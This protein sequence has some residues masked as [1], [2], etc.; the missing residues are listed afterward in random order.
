MM[1]R[2]GCLDARAARRSINNTACSIGS[3]ARRTVQKPPLRSNA[4]AMAISQAV[5]ESTAIART[6]SV[7]VENSVTKSCMARVDLPAY[8]AGARAPCEARAATCGL[9]LTHFRVGAEARVLLNTHQTRRNNSAIAIAASIAWRLYARAIASAAGLSR[10]LVSTP[11][12]WDAGIK[13]D[14][15]QTA[16]AF[17]SDEIK[18]SRVRG[19]H[20][21]GTMASARPAAQGAGGQR[22]LNAPVPVRC[23][24]PAGRAELAQLPARR[25]GSTDYGSL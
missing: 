4:P 2:N 14:A 1:T 11:S 5:H 3:A 9:R 17:T 6:M 7:S 15:L 20:S 8:S 25:P 18:M 21:R 16:R 24:A 12:Y 10:S 22:Q 19:S 13:H 23:A